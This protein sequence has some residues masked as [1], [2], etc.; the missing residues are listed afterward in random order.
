MIPPFFQKENRQISLPVQSID[1][2]GSLL[3]FYAGASPI[4]LKF[5]Q[6]YNVIINTT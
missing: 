1:K 4:F 3:K 5:Q 2:N 6:F